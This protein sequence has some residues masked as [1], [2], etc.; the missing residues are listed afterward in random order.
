MAGKSRLTQTDERV[1]DLCEKE[2]ADYELAMVT[3]LAIH[4]QGLEKE[5]ARYL[6]ET[7]AASFMGVYRFVTDLCDEKR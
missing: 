5:V 6:D 2:R 4:E 7:P 1:L 3:V